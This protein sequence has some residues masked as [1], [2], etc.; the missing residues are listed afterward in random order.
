M[1]PACP[2]NF[3]RLSD[4][5]WLPD[6]TKS[7]ASHDV[8]FKDGLCGTIEV[9]LYCHTPLMVGGERA[10]ETTARFFRTP[11]QDR[12]IPGS[13]LRGLLRN[14]VEIAGFGRMAFVDDRRIGLRDLSGAAAQMYRGLMVERVK[15]ASGP[16]WRARPRGGW[17][18]FDRYHPEGP[19]WVIRECEVFRIEHRLLECK[20]GA[21]ASVPQRLIGPER[22]AALLKLKKTTAVGFIAP[23]DDQPVRTRK[24]GCLLMRLVV[25]IAAWDADPPDWMKEDH[26]CEH[27]WIVLTG[28]PGSPNRHRDFVFAEP[29]SAAQP[30][31]IPAA[32]WRD[33]LATN[34]GDTWSRWR[35]MLDKKEVGPGAAPHLEN[36]PA[37]PGIP[38][39]WL[40]EA[41]M[42]AGGS[43]TTVASLGLAQMFKV[44]LPLS[45]HDM[46]RNTSPAHLGAEGPDL[47]Q[48]LFGTAADDEAY[49]LRGRVVCGLAREEL[50]KTSPAG[51]AT[52]LI[53][54]SPKPTYFPFYV[55]Q[56][57]AH[58]NSSTS[59]AGTVLG[60]WRAYAPVNGPELRGWKRYPARTGQPAPQPV[61]QQNR[62]ATTL[63]DPAA[64][65]TT[66]AFTIRVHNLRPFEL[67]ALVWAL[68]FGEDPASDHSKRTYRH[69]LGI[70]KPYGF[71]TVTLRV[72]S[73]RLTKNELNTDGKEVVLT[74]ADTTKALLKAMHEF[75]S[76]IGTE[77]QSW[78]SSPQIAQ[79]LAMAKPREP[80][81]EPPL[82]YMVLDRNSKRDDFAALKN[83]RRTLPDPA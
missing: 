77:V 35:T 55:R 16:A 70:A 68:A 43:P 82:R 41:D 23:R 26:I 11:E 3:V 60:E 27:G 76:R 62:V 4:T 49:S 7:P 30:L 51:S 80:N 61:P 6:G 78:D 54:Q 19:A 14:V 57:M 63:Q 65:G 25:D 2:Y 34:A 9:E 36:S 53:L 52:T 8:P 81:A 58:R 38:V 5:V 12:A 83:A 33:F 13:S 29:L 79:L 24:G 47:A 28:H 45:I 39:F 74:N 31:R 22:R 46:I 32:V 44:A 73:V 67:G 18:T 1:I 69:A 48:L 40:S 50:Q 66:F 56:I 71:G 75:K 15:T 21:G 59:K 64:K 20:L 72:R 10:G 17:L 42:R 37:E